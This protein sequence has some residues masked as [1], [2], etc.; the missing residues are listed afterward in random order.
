[1]CLSTGW[2]YA[3]YSGHNWMAVKYSGEAQSEVFADKGYALIPVTTM[4]TMSVE[5]VAGGM[6]ISGRASWGSGIVHA[7]WACVGG[8]LD[9]GTRYQFLVP[10]SDTRVVDTWHMS[11]MAG[12]G[13]HDFEIDEVFVPE[14]RVLLSADYRDGDTPGAR[15]HDNPQY[16]MPILP[17]IYCETMGIFSG[18]IRGAA[19]AFEDVVR[20]RVR[21]HSGAALAD[22]RYSHVKL[23]EAGAAADVAERLVDGLTQEAI[24]LAE[25]GGLTM[26]DRVRL[27]ARAGFIVD[28]CRRAVNDIVHHSG[29]SNFA[30]DAP[31]QRFFRD[32]NM[33]ATHAFYEWDTCREQLGRASLGLEP[34]HPLV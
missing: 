2:I 6:M 22:N 31:V 8:A 5:P 29:S 30:T 13:S 23:G 14:H 28:H 24:D 33:L 20:A 15:L 21:T 17:F 16:L 9:D 1:A 7:D 12:T 11:A 19:S 10:A 34:N 4:P 25:S 27:K 3:F 32:F 26:D 18:G